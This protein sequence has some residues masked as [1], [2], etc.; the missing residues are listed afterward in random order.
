MTMSMSYPLNN[1]AVEV[2]FYATPYRSG[3]VGHPDNWEP[4][5][6]PEVEIEEVVY[7]TKGKAFV[8]GKWIKCDVKVDVSPLLSDGQLEDID[9]K[10]CTTEFNEYD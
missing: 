1:D 4:D 9:E 6:M 10:I 8:D 7:Q 5:E 2:H 3:R